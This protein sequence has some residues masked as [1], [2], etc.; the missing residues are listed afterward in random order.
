MKWISVKDRLPKERESVLIH[1]CFGN[2]PEDETASAYYIKYNDGTIRW[3]E[4]GASEKE[5][6][7]AYSH[8]VFYWGHYPNFINPKES[9]GDAIV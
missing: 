9:Q 5:D 2:T 1:G 8:E 4:S 7:L 6:W 3:F